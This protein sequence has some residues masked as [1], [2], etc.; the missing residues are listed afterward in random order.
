M[1]A[2]LGSLL[3]ALSASRYRR[4]L[5]LLALGIVLVICA[6]SAGQIWLNAW[7]GD[8]FDAIEQRD[9]ATFGAELL[10]FGL[11][12]GAL[13]VLVVAQTWLKEMLQVGLRE[14]LTHDLLD[15]WL[16]SKR[17][18]LL[19]HAGEIGA[20]P[21]QRVQEDTRHLIDLSTDLAVGLLQSSLLLISFVSVLWLLSA[22][23]I[24]M[25]GERS[26]MIPGYMVWCALA[27]AIGGSWLAWRVGRPLIALNA[28][29]YA[30]EAE[31]RFALVRVSENA[32]GIALHGSEAQERLILDHPV[33]RVMTVMRE[34]ASGLARLTWVTSSY[35]WLAL[36]APILVAAPGYFSGGL[37]F[38]GLIMVIG[39]FNQVQQALRWYVDNFSRIA[40]WRATLLRV[41]A[42]RDALEVLD[43][44][45]RDPAPA[46]VAIQASEHVRLDNLSLAVGDG[47]AALELAQVAIAAGERVLIVA[48]H[49]SDRSALFRALAGLWPWGTGTIHLPPRDTMMFMPPR[50]YLPLGSLRAGASY[51]AAPER[52][53]HA[54]VTAALERVGLRH[55]APA[56]DREERWDQRLSQEEQQRLSFARL[57]LH[58]P[59]WVLLDDALGALDQKQ[60]QSLLAIFEHE[61]IDTAVIGIGR[62]PARNG[63][64]DRTLHFGRVDEGATLLPLRQ[65]PARPPASRF[66]GREPDRRLGDVLQQPREDRDHPRRRSDRGCRSDHRRA[67]RANRRAIRRHDADRSGGW[68]Q[69]GQ[70]RVRLHT[71]GSG[72]ARA[73]RARGLPTEA[74]ARGRG[75]GR[76]AGELRLPRR[77]ER[78]RGKDADRDAHQRSR[79]IGLRMMHNVLLRLALSSVDV[80]P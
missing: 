56:L 6:N 16:T 30:R 39:A 10:V 18:Y 31:L 68:R 7:Q 54:S 13:L 65:R 28:T 26:F 23:V 70:P 14:W 76:R 59:S 77:Q 38:G 35:G 45:G 63:F 51:P 69:P 79:W 1:I 64:F 29:R 75:P 8:F 50:P 2:Q 53:D 42:L 33:D 3:A 12:V 67:H 37:S 21:D 78:C 66:S 11:I 72:E 36:V 74:Q 34:L 43:A 41:V 47:R 44:T 19:A 24:F 25:V 49:G 4:R 32:E 17:A 40:D 71:L 80:R 73:H 57:L 22:R 61:L 9:C 55:L 60:R 52:F 27:Y 46:A 58:R 62:S 48:E 5:G 15:R 20:N